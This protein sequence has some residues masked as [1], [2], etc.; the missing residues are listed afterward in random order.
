[1]VYPMPQQNPNPDEWD[2]DEED[3]AWETPNN[4]LYEFGCL[5]GDKCLMPGEHFKSE[6]HTREM[7]EPEKSVE[8]SRCQHLTNLHIQ[9]GSETGDNYSRY[10]IRVCQ[11]CGEFQVFTFK[12]GQF[13][14]LSFAL[15][16]EEQLAAAA[17]YR[18]R[19]EN[20]V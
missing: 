14:N 2:G 20:D 18:M 8:T 16:T 10:N 11:I 5:F 9:S 1:M 12:N 7:M 13:F 17:R 3:G 15:V 19:L 4:E 6:C